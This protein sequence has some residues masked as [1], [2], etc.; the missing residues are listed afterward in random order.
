MVELLV[1]VEFHHLVSVEF[2]HLVSVEFATP[3]GKLSFGN[4]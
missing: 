4:R 2:H 3:N 1:S